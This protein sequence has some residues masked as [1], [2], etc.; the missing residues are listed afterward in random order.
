MNSSIIVCEK[1][2]KTLIYHNRGQGC[3]HCEENPIIP[4]VMDEQITERIT[5]ILKEE[6]K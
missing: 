5:E 2:G 1:C 6:A 4:I 3:P